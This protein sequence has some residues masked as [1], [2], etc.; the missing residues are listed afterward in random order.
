M[1]GLHL[2]EIEPGIAQTDIS[3]IILGREV[4][5]GSSLDVETFRLL[6][7]DAF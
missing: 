5:I 2:P 4:K 7:A 3:G 1:V 6:S